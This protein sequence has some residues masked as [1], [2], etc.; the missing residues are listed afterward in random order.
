[1]KYV[2]EI[3][4]RIAVYE[5]NKRIGALYKTTCGKWFTTIHVGPGK[6][7]GPYDTYKK[8][9]SDLVCEV[10]RSLA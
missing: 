9:Q 10:E 5:N 3:N 8:A 4:G 1:M 7:W 6:I 2:K